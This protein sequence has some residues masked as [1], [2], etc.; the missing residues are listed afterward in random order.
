MKSEYFFNV[1][2]FF[3]ECFYFSSPEFYDD[4]VSTLI[5]GSDVDDVP[6]PGLVSACG[7]MQLSKNR[8]SKVA[9]AA[10]SLMKY[11][12]LDFQELLDGKKIEDVDGN[13]SGLNVFAETFSG[14]TRSNIQQMKFDVHLTTMVDSNRGNN[15]KHKKETCLLVSFLLINHYREAGPDDDDM[16]DGADI[17][18]DL[19]ALEDVLVTEDSR[20]VFKGWLSSK[21]S[22]AVAIK[23]LVSKTLDR[24]SNIVESFS[25]DENK[26]ANKRI[27]SKKILTRADENKS[28]PEWN[29]S[30]VL[31][32]LSNAPTKWADSKFAHE[33]AQLFEQDG[34]AHAQR[35]TQ[36][37]EEDEIL[38]Q[39]AREESIQRELARDP[40]DIHREDD[41][42]LRLIQA[43][44]EQ[45]REEIERG[46][47]KDYESLG[48]NA[49]DIDNS[50]LSL[51]NRLKSLSNVERRITIGEDEATR[52]K[53]ERDASILLTV[54]NF[55]S[56]SFLTYAH[57]SASMGD[58]TKGLTN[59]KGEI[60]F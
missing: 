12:V 24:K 22:E 45:L 35:Q 13:G 33:V 37:E 56:L 46:I 34:G 20:T 58:L 14:L 36:K 51:D 57:P 44:R 26:L 60:F 39:R 50:F 11:L 1:F 31:I 38:E 6:V 9:V 10:L 29:E 16:L 59:I 43:R 19:L 17:I 55:D 47:L 52:N 5:L 53:V 2:L 23:K 28:E 18:P 3:L 7:E 54:A 8:L 27:P 42:D 15:A 41:F 4:D 48:T 32:D 40:L 25:K 49:K 30:E 21:D